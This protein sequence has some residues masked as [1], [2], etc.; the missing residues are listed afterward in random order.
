M[1]WEFWAGVLF[2]TS[3]LILS[4]DWFPAHRAS[5]FSCLHY[6]IKTWFHKCARPFPY[7]QG[8][9]R[10]IWSF[11]PHFH[12]QGNDVHARQGVFPFVSFETHR[13]NKEAISAHA[14]CCSA[15]LTSSNTFYQDQSA[16]PILRSLV[17]IDWAFLRMQPGGLWASWQNCLPQSHGLGKPFNPHQ[18]SIWM[19]LSRRFY[20]SQLKSAL[21]IS[22]VV[23][24][25]SECPPS[26]VCYH[27]TTDSLITFGVALLLEQ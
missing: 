20:L 1:P 12:L 27:C 11:L 6:Y 5:S 15:S 14:L 2:P 19:V 22:M 9:Y 10:G 21:F 16:G 23:L 18:A 7:T 4:F 8:H 3:A 26:W 17:Q 24:A 25:L 13:A